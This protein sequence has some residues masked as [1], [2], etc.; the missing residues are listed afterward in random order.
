MLKFLAI[1]AIVQLAQSTNSGCIKGPSYWCKTVQTANECNAF[2]HCLQSVWSKQSSLMNKNLLK[3]TQECSKCVNCLYSDIRRCP[4]IRVFKDEISTLFEKNLPSESICKLIDQCEPK[5]VIDSEIKAPEGCYLAN[6][7]ESFDMAARCG[8]MSVC[9]KEWKTSK[10]YQLKQT[11]HNLLTESQINEENVCGF[12]IYIMNQYQSIIQQNTTETDVSNYFSSAC[13]LLPTPE[14]TQKCTDQITKYL[15]QIFNVLRDNADPGVICHAIQLCKDSHLE[16]KKFDVSQIKIKIWNKDKVVIK[17]PLSHPETALKMS[18]TKGMGCEVCTIVFD[19]AKFLVKDEVDNEK[20]LKFIEQNLCKRLGSYS[21]TCADYVAVDGEQIIQFLEDE[22]EPAFICAELGICMNTQIKVARENPLNLRAKN[23][24]TCTQCQL[25]MEHVKQMENGFEIMNYI[26]NNFCM[27]NGDMK[28]LCSSTMDAHSEIILAII[29]QDIKSHQLCEIFAVCSIEEIQPE[30]HD[31]FYNIDKPNTVAKV[32]SNNNNCMICQFLIKLL[33]QYIYK[34]ST[35]DEIREGLEK[36][37]SVAFP[38]QYKDECRQFVDTYTNTIIFLIA[39]KIP[40]EYICETIGACS[41]TTQINEFLKQYDLNDTKKVLIGA[42]EKIIN[43]MPKTN[44]A[45]CVLC[46]FAI[47]LLSKTI[48]QNATQKEL[49]D[50]LRY[51][52][53]KEIPASIRDQCNQFV[54]NYGEQVIEQIINELDP[55]QICT[56]INLCPAKKL[57]G[58]EGLYKKIPRIHLKK[59]EMNLINLKPAKPTHIVS[60]DFKLFSEKQDK[61]SL[62]CTLCIYTAELADNFL[63]KNKTQE[64]IET[65]LRMVCN[66]FPKNLEAECG[67]FINEYGPYVIELIAA[68]LEPEDVCAKMKFCGASAEKNLFAFNKKKSQF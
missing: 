9:L 57:F 64:E 5:K 24:S 68:D 61:E 45:E 36:V 62:S 46:E 38:S 18:G 3:N 56:Q 55:V 40:A 34:D 41:K 47:T 30:T 32:V 37:C 7:C 54:D 11:N 14:L 31:L 25:T 23:P 4:Q 52:C 27:K 63:K 17:T 12:C 49:M 66:F 29:E 48:K 20:V 60:D 65:E 59:T 6:I 53:N 22:L 15:S 51:V 33:D 2:K 1:L 13:R 67:A 10:K 16:E 43:K 8:F 35:E 21:K 44:K 19:A 39:K 26:K 58:S 50:D 42:E 28:Y